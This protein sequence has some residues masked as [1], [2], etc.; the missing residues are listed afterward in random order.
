[1]TA[2]VEL[3]SVE[4][5]KLIFAVEAHDGIDVISRGRHERY[6]IDREK[7]DGKV[8]GKKQKSAMDD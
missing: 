3:V 8:N 1:V 7:F 2:T 4:G 5:R 6:V